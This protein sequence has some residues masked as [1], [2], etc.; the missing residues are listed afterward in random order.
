MWPLTSLRVK[1]LNLD[2]LI[3]NQVSCRVGRTRIVVG[4]NFVRM[5]TAP[6]WF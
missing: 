4:T 5:V 6:A 1:D 3:Q 2:Y